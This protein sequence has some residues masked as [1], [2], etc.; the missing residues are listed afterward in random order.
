MSPP[1]IE[2]LRRH[3]ELALLIG[4]SSQLE[5]LPTALGSVHQAE[6]R[7]A[8]AD[9][10][11]AMAKVSQILAEQVRAYVGMVESEVGGKRRK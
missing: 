9:Q 6:D 8:L 11:R 4:L 2:R 1:S 3:P 5:L 10:A 7:R